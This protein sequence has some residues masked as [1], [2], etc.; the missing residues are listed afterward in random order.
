MVDEVATDPTAS[1]WARHSRGIWTSFSVLLGLALAIDGYLK[2]ASGYN[3]G[4]PPAIVNDIQ[5]AQAANPSWLSGWF[6]FWSTLA[7]NNPT[8][9]VY[10]VGTFEVLIGLALIFGFFRK[11]AYVGG[12]I[13][14]LLIW[15]IP[16]GFGEIFPISGSGITDVGTGLIYA[17]ALVGMIAI[18]AAVGPNPY[19]LDYYIERR[20]PTWA[21]FAEFGTPLWGPMK[22]PVAA[23]PKAPA[24]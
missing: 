6:S 18:S 12:I 16:E 20:F 10:A 1:W 17:I 24:G 8:G 4:S 3:T 22:P 14:T 19:T 9:L 21:R 2:F 23:A 11:F 15:T 5:T 7:S 13:L